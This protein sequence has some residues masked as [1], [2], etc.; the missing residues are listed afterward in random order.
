M[1]TVAVLPVKRFAGAKQRLGEHLGPGSRR[2]LAEAMLSDVLIALRR[3]QRVDEVVVVTGEPTAEALARGHGAAVVRDP[4]D[5]GHS[6]AALLGVAWAL[7]RG[8]TRAL[9]VPGDCPALLPAEL[10]A[11]LAPGPARREVVV[12]PDRHGTGTNAL[13]LSPPD[14]IRPSFGPGSRARHESLAHAA[15]VECRVAEP[16]S[17][18]LDVDTAEDLEA[19]A[20]ALGERT[21]GAANTRGLLGRLER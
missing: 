6:Q 4:D 14:A 15:Q 3:S 5:A 13:V 21:G 11:L 8:A 20:Q 2:R 1:S 18:A 10:D 17:L 16:F 12:V 7:E 19:L 9:L